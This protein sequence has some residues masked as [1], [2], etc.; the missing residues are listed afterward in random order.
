MKVNPEQSNYATSEL[1][2]KHLAVNSEEL[3]YISKALA[4]MVALTKNVAEN[5]R[6]FSDK[7]RYEMQDV[8]DKY[9]KLK[10]K[11]DLI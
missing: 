5:T 1:E 2:W 3:E 7:V 11:I 10:G 8:S 4:N 6:D 9:L